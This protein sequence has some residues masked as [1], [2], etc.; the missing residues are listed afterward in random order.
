V[1]D[2]LLESRS[3]RRRSAGGAII[4]VTA[5]TALIAVALYA[6]AQAHVPSRRSPEQVRP[7]YFP[8]VPMPIKGTPHQQSGRTTNVVPRLPVIQSI[9]IVLPPIP[10][11]HVPA[12]DGGI[13]HSR[14]LAGSGTEPVGSAGDPGGGAY[15]AGQVE[16]QVAVAPGNSPPKYPEALRD[17][18]VEGSVVAQFVVDE[19]G[20]VESSSVRFT[21]SD[22]VLFE[23]AV[24]AALAR[25]RF[26]PAEVGGRR[27]RQLVQMPFVFTIG[28]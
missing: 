7:V 28:E 1:L 16:R 21:R 25:M 4:S 14:P 10:D 5:H 17:R 6:T 9:D 8:P 12:A 11:I 23:A 3:T 24:R 26:V 19:A 27:V 22:N 20:R 15:T 2:T 13:F 18:G